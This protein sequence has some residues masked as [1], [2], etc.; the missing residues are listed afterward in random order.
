M[1]IEIET[2]RAYLE[3]FCI[4]IEYKKVFT[5]LKDKTQQYILIYERINVFNT[6]ELLFKNERKIKK[7]LYMLKQ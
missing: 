4:Y 3:I 2:D 5:L 1:K 6:M 7:D